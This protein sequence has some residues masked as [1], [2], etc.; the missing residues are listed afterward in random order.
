[1]IC[2]INALIETPLHYCCDVLFDERLF[3]KVVVLKQEH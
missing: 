2:A 1:M 3:L